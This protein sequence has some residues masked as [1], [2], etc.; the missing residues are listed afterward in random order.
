MGYTALHWAAIRGNWRIFSELVAAGAPVN[1]VGSDG[2]TPLHWACHHDRADMIELL[3]DAGA[4][5]SPQ[6]RWGRTP[7]H[8]AA[9]RGCPSVALLLVRQ[10]AAVDAETKEGWTPLH[11][12]YLSNHP[13]VVRVLLDSGA[14]PEKIDEEG[15]TPVASSRP[16][17]EPEE[18]E[19]KTLSEYEGIYSLGGG[20]SVKVW[21]ADQKLRI[22]EFAPDALYPIGKDLFFCEQEPW[23]VE[24]ERD[25]NGSISAIQIDFLRRSVRGIKAAS[26]RYVGSKV[27]MDCHV[28]AD[29]GRQYVAWLRS[30]HAHAYWRLGGDWAQF[31]ASL[32]PN[33]QDLTSPISD[34]RCLLCHV[35]GAQD[36]QALFASSFRP[37][38]GIGCESCHGP[39]SDYI[40]P[41]VMAERD[42]FLA[43]GGRVPDEAI[44][45]SCHRNSERF[46]WAESWPKIAHPVPDA[47]QATGG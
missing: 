19:S 37:E 43:N 7:L 36:D 21:L 24:F 8:V 3:L 26:P 9:R 25:Q 23:R 14:D 33:Y 10:G 46:D 35:T 22:R 18:N 30:R 20:F 27:C 47:N 1:A 28:S 13:D 31:L 2:G 29:S 5:V 38:E 15:L 12:A 41:E 17:P 4:E 42:A 16:R 32:R 6:N 44:C 40:D 45:R 34:D 39:G 11:V